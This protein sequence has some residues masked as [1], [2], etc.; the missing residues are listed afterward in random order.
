MLL[1]LCAGGGHVDVVLSLFGEGAGMPR[2]FALWGGS[3]HVD[4]AL[5]SRRVDTPM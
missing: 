1:S 5:F 3:G 2:F 4:V